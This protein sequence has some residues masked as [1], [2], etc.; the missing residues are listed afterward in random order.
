MLAAAMLPANADNNVLNDRSGNPFMVE[1]VVPAAKT[2]ALGWHALYGAYSC[3]YHHQYALADRWITYAKYQGATSELFRA[4]EDA[5][6]LSALLSKVAA[7]QKQA[8]VPES[9]PDLLVLKALVHGGT[10]AI[11]MLKRVV[12]NNPTYPSLQYLKAKI[13]VME[14]EADGLPWDVPPDVSQTGGKKNEFYRWKAVKFPLKVYIPADSTASKVSGYQAG[15][16]QLLRSAFET[17]HKQS[18]GKVRFVYVPVQTHAD[19]TC[20]WLSD[21]KDMP[22][23]NAIGVCYRDAN[24]N[25]YLSHADIKILTFPSK[26]GNSP[27]GID[28]QYRRKYLEETCL[29]EIGHSLGLNHSLSDNDIMWY[30]A[31]LHPTT[32]LTRGDVGAFDS[33]YTTD[34]HT[35]LSG[36]VDSMQIGDY[37]SALASLEKARLLNPKDGQISDIICICF[38]KSAKEAVERNDFTT[39][40]SLLAKAKELAAKSTSKKTK[41]LILKHLQYAYLLSGN[42]KA[43]EDLEKEHPSMQLDRPNSASFLDQ[44][45]LKRESIPHYETALANSPDDLSIRE[46]FCFLLVTLAKDELSS[47]NDAQAISFLIRAKGL[48]R[49]ALTSETIDKVMGTLQQTYEKEGRYDEADQTAKE[50]VALKPPPPAPYKDTSQEE[51]ADLIAAA[52]KA[53]PEAWSSPGARKSQSAKISQAYAQYADAL[54]S[55]AEATNTKDGPTWAIAFIVRHKQYDGRKTGTPF[56]SLFSCRHRLMDLTD[57]EAVIGLES[58]IPLKKFVRTTPPSPAEAKN[59]K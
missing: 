26:S 5:G 46:K 16:D 29:H 48:L 21:P 50:L 3:V 25:N 32:V 55:C 6:Y 10:E 57:E 23:S 8:A 22:I 13:K 42:L 17:W 36:A 45:G 52:K 24:Y 18:G 12:I 27:A 39:A 44:Y 34:V 51:I 56:D 37:K 35:Y 14:L 58:R 54:R 30:C 33:L 7:S 28:S 4:G 38:A 1:D 31:H 20:G 49:P 43:E 40:M 41:D 15:D 47:G 59:S 53:H 11:E 19:I 2:E 9:S